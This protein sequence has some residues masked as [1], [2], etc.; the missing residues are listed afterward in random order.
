V[1]EGL[2][3]LG[4]G[5][6]RRAKQR[7]DKNRKLKQLAADLSLDST[8]CR[9][10]RKK[11]MVHPVLA[12]VRCSWQHSLRKCIWLFMGNLG[13]CPRERDARSMIKLSGRTFNQAV[14][15]AKKAAERGP[16]F[17]AKRGRLTHVLLTVDAYGQI[18]GDRP[19]NIVDLLATQDGL[20]GF[21]PP[22]SGKLFHA[23]ELS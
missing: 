16:V 3:R 19:A 10:A 2:W 9:R 22:R 6:Q 12:S 8:S 17:I 18:A 13:P 7:E 21:E 15:E 4:V 5:E 20:A 11:C 1:E 23:A 14:S